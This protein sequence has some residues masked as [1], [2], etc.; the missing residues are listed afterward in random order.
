MR[1]CVAA[2]VTAFL[3][4]S[5]LATVCSHGDGNHL[6]IVGLCHSHGHDVCSPN[7]SDSMASTG[8][9]TVSHSSVLDQGLMFATGNPG[10]DMPQET[11][12]DPVR[13]ELPPDEFFPPSRLTASSPPRDPSGLTV[14]LLL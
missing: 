14:S 11:G 12:A 4:I 13:V 6:E 3:G 2:L 5:T 7:G 8:D 1:T 9:E 10:S